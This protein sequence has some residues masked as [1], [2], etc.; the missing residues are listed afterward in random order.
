MIRGLGEL[1]RKRVEAVFLKHCQQED[2]WPLSDCGGVVMRV[3]T[4]HS[5]VVFF[6]E[7]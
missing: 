7:N 6:Q 2:K 4:V 1:K 5:P 3:A